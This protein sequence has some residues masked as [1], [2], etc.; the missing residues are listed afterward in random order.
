MLLLPLPPPPPPPPQPPLWGASVDGCSAASRSVRTALRIACADVD[1]IPFESIF[2]MSN[3]GA[4]LL[5]RRAFFFR[6][7][8]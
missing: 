7:F 6:F 8:L 3:D 4:W 1:G 5:I 2:S